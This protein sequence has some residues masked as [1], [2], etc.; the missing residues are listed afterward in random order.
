M[1]GGLWLFFFCKTFVS[2]F[3]SSPPLGFFF[4]CAASRTIVDQIISNEWRGK[5]VR[6]SST[7][8]FKEVEYP[9]NKKQIIFFSL[10]QHKQTAM[11]SAENL[12]PLHSTQFD[13]PAIM[14]S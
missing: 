4:S 14:S 5:K 11:G 3:F 6:R 13:I 9:Y 2:G 8:L 12:Y 7:A 1:F 10:Y